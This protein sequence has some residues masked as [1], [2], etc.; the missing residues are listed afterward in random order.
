MAAIV[1][2][3]GNMTEA[4]RESLMAKLSNLN[5]AYAQAKSRRDN[6]ACFILMG[7]IDVTK[8]MIKELDK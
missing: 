8:E 7:H 6:I 4:T 3:H 5:D 2:N 1:R